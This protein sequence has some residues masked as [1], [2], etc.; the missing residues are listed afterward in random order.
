MERETIFLIPQPRRVITH[1]QWL[2]LSPA[3]SR[4]IIE[5]RLTTEQLPGVTIRHEA[6]LPPEGYR[7][8]IDPQG[9]KIG[10]GDAAGRFWAL[11]TLRQLISGPSPNS[12]SPEPRHIESNQPVSQRTSLPCL[13][14]EDHPF[15]VNRGFMLDISRDRV[16]TLQTLELLIDLLASLKLNQLQLYCEHVFA[17]RGHE[18]VWADSSA[19]SADEMRH[20]IAYAAERGVTLVANQNSYGHMER[21]L[22][23]YTHLAECPQGFTDPWGQFRPEPSTLCPILPESSELIADLYRQY[24]PLFPSPLVNIGGDEPWEHCAGRSAAICRE[25]GSGRIYLDF[26][27]KLRELAAAHNKRIQMWGDIIGKYPELIA[28]LPAD[29]TLMEWG[30]EADHPFAANCARYRAAGL[31]FGVCPGT[32]AWNSLGGRWHNAR[33]NLSNAARSGHEQGATDYLITDWGDNGHRHQLPILLPGLV[34]G[35][36]LA[37]NSQPAGDFARAPETHI[38]RWLDRQLFTP[39]ETERRPTGGLAAAL[40]RLGELPARHGLDLP[41][42][43]LPAI[44]AI[45]HIFPY[46]RERYESFRSYDWG[47]IRSELAELARMPGGRPAGAA[48]AWHDELA[49]TCAMLSHACEFAE[50]FLQTANFRAAEIVQPQRRRLHDH[51]EPIIAEYRRLWALRS[52]PGGLENSVKRLLSL[53][54]ELA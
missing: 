29:I 5:S 47:P 27:L 42:A 12:A 23:I 25:R 33:G 30:Y 14:I 38:E 28:E 40:L 48:A 39:G 26:I 44:I 54:R 31:H 22:R 37:W 43:S 16:P 21:W 20:I 3:T 24:L 45:D 35:A 8:K 49:L 7:L 19:Y 4:A 46:Y 15:F 52:R 9:I 53:Q 13:E 51:L 50:S 18:A 1:R 36:A 41:N 6:A 10:A 17:Y 2:R 32:S 34:Y 11:Q